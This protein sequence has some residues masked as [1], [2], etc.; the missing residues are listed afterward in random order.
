MR[1]LN[2]P[3]ILGVVIL[4]LVLLV[5]MYPEYF[6]G[7]D[8]YSKQRLEFEYVNGESKIL[9]PPV[10]PCKE[11]PWGTDH[12]GRDIRS[13]IAHGCKT[14]I[15]LAF[16]I[17]VFRLL[18][19]L[20]LAIAAAYKNKLAHW[21]IKQF[22]VLFS[23]FPLLILVL[24]L[25]NI[26]FIAE[27]SEST[28][29]AI[30]V[31]L[32]I[33]G[34]SKMAYLLMQ[35]VKEVLDQDFIE[36]EVAVGKNRLEIALQNIIPHIIPS[37]IVQFFLEVAIV[38][39]TLSQI[40]VFSIVLGGGYFVGLYADHL[41][42]P[43]DFDWASMLSLAYIYVST[44]KF[45]IVF[46]PALAFAVSIIGF[47]LFGEGLRIEFDKRNSKVISFIRRIPALIS[48][49]RF[50]Y[51]IKN[52]NEYKPLVIKKI[53]VIALLLL[54]MFFPEPR[55]PYRFEEELAFKY[56][57]EITGEK[58]EGRVAGSEENRILAEFLASKLKEYGVEPY[59]GSYIHEYEIEESF[60]FY[61]SELSIVSDNS[62]DIV[63]DYR[64]DYIVT[65]PMTVEGTYDLEYV[66][67]KQLYT[68]HVNPEEASRLRE[69]F[70][71]IDMRGINQTEYI[72][73]RNRL[74]WYVRPQGVVL[75]EDWLSRNDDYKYPRVNKVF[76]DSHVILVS[77]NKG[78][79]LLELENPKIHVK[80]KANIY[81]YAAGTNVIGIIKG[82]DSEASNE[83]IVIG[84]SMDYIG[85]DADNRYP[86]ATASGGMA[87]ELELARVI[88]ESGRRPKKDIIIAFWDGTY[89]SDRGS[90]NF[91]FN[92][93]S[94]GKKYFFMD[95]RDLIGKD[96]ESIIL[97]T[98]NIIP[99]DVSA[100][101]YIKSLKKSAKRNDINLK[102]GWVYSPVRDDFM[103]GDKAV[104]VIQSLE[105][106]GKVMTPYDDIEYI[107][108]KR[109][110]RVGQMIIDAV[111]D[112]AFNK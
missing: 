56:I 40:G 60:N 85:D 100:Q 35:K 96:A 107:D 112:I 5:S 31:L 20:P 39:L 25:T 103:T 92:M 80:A 44:G 109:Y 101:N 72:A 90:R 110:S 91:V 49:V 43:A 51:E 52:I 19:A 37:I 28:W 13:L 71:L 69:C 67:H 23:A 58:Y 83:R 73:I 81:Q 68:T 62:E 76:R 86:G 64:N 22:N 29:G 6:S 105:K 1:K 98:S 53:A 18:I 47:N 48:P 108:K 7:A 32:I 87:I 88:K 59:E 93:K 70:L 77:S 38:L 111:M 42:V 16:T 46:Y 4:L 78:N 11:Y 75:I 26:R 55:N 63:L 30:A 61:D 15:G 14:T 8:P 33:L 97:D 34:W 82:T 50:I 2:Y 45:W 3:L 9:T 99:K 106:K 74:T 17:A 36:G 65:T 79:E 54:V 41:N 57:D 84:S 12:L 24:L 66:T 21:V 89:S 104:V 94:D 10:A 95:I 27:I 102:F